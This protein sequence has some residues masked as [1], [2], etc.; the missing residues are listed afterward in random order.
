[1]KTKRQALILRLIR[2]R[3]IETQEELAELLRQ[4]GIEVTQATVS[5]DVKE[6][7]LVKVPTGNGRYRYEAPYESTSGDV[8]HRARRSFQDY[9][10]EVNYTQNLI[11]IKTLSGTANAVAAAID[12]LRWPEI[13]GTIAGDDTILVIVKADADE[14]TVEPVRHILEEFR[15]LRQQG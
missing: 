13:L 8:L 6:L 12:A 9:V 10:I 5:R 14:L 2:E 11:I 7:R 3:E 1:M 15:R 4:E